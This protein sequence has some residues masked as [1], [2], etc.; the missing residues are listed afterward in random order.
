[1]GPGR[2]GNM[3]AGLFSVSPGQVSQHGKMVPELVCERGRATVWCECSVRTW[4]YRAGRGGRARRHAQ[5]S[6]EL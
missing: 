6:H 2:A 3:H 4:R 5:E 1:M